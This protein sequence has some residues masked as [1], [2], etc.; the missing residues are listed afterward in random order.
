MVV[1][2]I[3]AEKPDQQRSIAAALG[4]V[5][6]KGYVL[7]VRD[8]KYLSGELHI[9]A[10]RGH[11]VE[12]DIQPP[13]WTMDNFPWFPEFKYSLKKKDEDIKKRF[14]TIKSEVKIADEIILSTDADR[15]GE[16]IGYT[17]LNLIPNGVKKLK[18][19]AWINSTT[20]KG[21][22]E[23]FSNLKKSS[24]TIN[25][26]YEAEARSQADYLI[27]YNMSPI[28][29][30]H[31]QNNGTL[32]KGALSVG[33]VQSAIVKI[34]IDNDKEIA[35]FVPEDYW[36]LSLINQEDDMTFT[37][38]DRYFDQ[39][40][41][42][43]ILDSLSDTAEITDINVERKSKSAKKLFD[44]DGLQ[45]YA[46]N[47]WGYA[48]EDVL[49][50]VQELYQEPLG[51]LTY[52]RTGI[53]YI[54]HEHFEM[55]KENLE[56]FKARVGM[57]FENSNMA[58]RKK[59]VNDKKVKEHFAIMPTDVIA[60]SEE[61][62]NFLIVEEIS[63]KVMAEQKWDVKRRNAYQK[64]LELAKRLAPIKKDIY[65]AV[66]KRVAL[67]FAPDYI[68]DETTVTVKCGSTFFHA[69]GKQI[70][71]LGFLAFEDTETKDKILP[72]FAQGQMIPV[73]P[74]IKQD[75]TRAPARITEATM[76]GSIM[77]V[78][79]KIGT[80]ATR[81]SILKV[82]QD[83]GYIKKNN[84][85][86]LFPLEKGINLIGAMTGS[87]FIDPETTGKWEKILKLIG[88]GKVQMDDFVKVVQEELVKEINK[89]KGL[90]A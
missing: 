81:A 58:P 5:E 59:Y 87:Q 49:S 68:Y 40:E 74:D 19:R 76:I 16:R 8:S 50:A 45:K 71:D 85:K 25:F 78:K 51:L 65:L 33:R 80:P 73:T 64:K 52:P 43:G 63:P 54:T 37:N 9:V 12:T 75:T 11:L 4:K 35:D 32:T 3:L 46:S 82:V 15:E 86:E 89:F 26:Y 47:K 55:L 18:Y 84:K 38:D 62:E 23:S 61:I 53:S 20:P 48:P 30:L 57:T 44:L 7:V 70:V 2:L 69:K 29:T 66:L 1:K 31:S 6:K 24:E 22:R 77:K 10:A 83:K 67:M 60:T 28:I 79:Y 21:L 39:A 13:K 56:V 88:Q 34:I 14:A 27:G 72:E 90:G 17:I 41:A 42:E 36:K